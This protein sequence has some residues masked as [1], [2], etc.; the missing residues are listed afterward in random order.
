MDGGTSVLARYVVSA[1][2]DV[3][4][5]TPDRILLTV[6]QPFDN[7]NGGDIIFGP[8]GYL[9]FGLGDGGSGGDPQGHGQDRTDLLGSLLRLDVSGSGD[10]T[11]PPT[12]PY[13]TSAT[14]KHEL[15]NWGLRNPWRFSFDRETGDLYIGDV[16]QGAVEEVDVATSTSTGGENYG[17]NEVEGD[18]CYTGGCDLAAYTAPVLTYRHTDGCAIIG[19]YVYRGSDLAG[20]AGTYFYSDACS[21]FVRSFRWSAGQVSD[22]NSWSALA[23]NDG[24]QSFGQDDRGE[25]YLLTA[26][27]RVL[28]IV[29]HP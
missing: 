12:N 11:I 19:G 21:G 25:L 1:D 28:K 3:A 15:W 18:Q 16:G 13:A 2:P 20:M 7:H 9:Y 8:D 26:G 22:R 29:K 17:W 24:V 5:A 6:D 14:L 23:V 27:G 10:Y 4:T